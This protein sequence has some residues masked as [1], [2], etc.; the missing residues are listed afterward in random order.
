MFDYLDNST[1]TTAFPAGHLA[2]QFIRHRTGRTASLEGLPSGQLELAQ[3]IISEI[4]LREGRPAAEIS[5]NRI[6]E[7][8]FQISERLQ[9]LSRRE[10][11]ADQVK[12]KNLLDKLRLV[13]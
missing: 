12:G 5:E 9:K 7:Y 10:L 6:D 11:H 3:R 13:R 1:I 2:I 8:V 4:E